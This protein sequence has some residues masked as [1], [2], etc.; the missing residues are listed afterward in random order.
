MG[1]F[2]IALGLALIATDVIVA[3]TVG[4]IDLFVLTLIGLVCWLTTFL[5]LRSL[6]PNVRIMRRQQAGAATRYGV[7]IGAEALLIHTDL[8]L[9]LIP[10]QNTVR[11]DGLQLHYTW[12]DKPKVLSLPGQLVGTSSDVLTRAVQACLAG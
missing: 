1:L 9:T 12:N 6:W 4:E 8:D 7:F 3:Q 5:L 11:L 10:R 2:F